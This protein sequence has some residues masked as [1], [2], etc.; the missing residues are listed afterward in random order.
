MWR[1]AARGVERSPRA[2]RRLTVASP[3]R[4]EADSSAKQG[5][6]EG[7]RMQIGKRL[8]SAGAVTVTMA[9]AGGVGDEKPIPPK[10][11]TGSGGM[12]AP[13]PA[14]GH[15]GSRGDGRTGARARARGPDVRQRARAE[16]V[17]RELGRLDQ[18]GRLGRE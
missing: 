10:G 3:R 18:R 6:R 12:G 16:R 15:D 11:I 14:Q 17:L 8:A 7:S 9:L 5:P 2:S 13:D 1:F 4:G